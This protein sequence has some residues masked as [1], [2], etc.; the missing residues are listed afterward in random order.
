MEPLRRLLQAVDDFQQRHRWLAFPVAVVKKY[1]EDQA[2]QRAALLAYYGFFSLFP[3]LLVAVTVLGFMLHGDSGLS[4]RIVDS[5]VGQFPVIGDDIGQSVSR[6]RLRGSGVALAVGVVFALWGGLGVAEAA[7]AA[8]NGI[9]NVPR[10]RYPNFLV[11]RLR[12]LAW[13][14]ILGG[15][16]LLASV[17]SGF[18]AAADTAW[19]GPAGVAASTLVNML[20]FLVGFRVLT[21]RNVSLRQLLPGAVLA[22]LAWALLQWLGGWYVARQL[23]RASA[24]Y[25]AFALVIGLLSW[26]YLAATV[27]LLAAELNVVRARRLWPRSLAPPPLGRPD[28]RALE[29]LAKQEERLPDQ[30][31][32]VSFGDAAGEEEPPGEEPARPGPPAQA[33]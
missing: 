20:L 24:T 27:T 8:M 5:A 1:G 19:S 28:E 2:G 32:E 23:S 6:S 29:S 10:R 13:L 22:A 17:V 4:R 31:V 9:W 15:G 33:G 21:V 7:Q 12:G 25:G 14:V 30:R 16:L 18:A 26:L 11:R 3:L